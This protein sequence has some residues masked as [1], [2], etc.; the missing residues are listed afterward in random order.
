MF[1]TAFVAAIVMV[2]EL[3]DVECVRPLL[4]T[5]RCLNPARR[6]VF[7]GRRGLG[8]ILNSGGRSL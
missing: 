2:G 8:S 7:D 1:P 6:C 3:I 5:Y 4:S